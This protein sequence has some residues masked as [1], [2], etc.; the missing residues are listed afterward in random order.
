MSPI[1]QLELDHLPHAV[2]PGYII[3]EVHHP[4]R[5]RQLIAAI[6]GRTPEDVRPQV[7]TMLPADRARPPRHDARDR[8]RAVIVS[9]MSLCVFPF[10]ARPMIAA[11][12]GVDQPGFEQFIARRRQDPGVLSWSVAA[13]GRDGCAAVVGG[14]FR[15]AA[16]A[17]KGPA[18]VCLPL[19]M[20]V[21]PGRC[22]SGARRNHCSSRRC[23]RASA[24]PRSAGARVRAA[25]RAGGCLQNIESAAAGGQ[26]ARL[27][28]NAV[29]RPDPS[30][31][32]QPAVVP[33][34]EGPYDISVRVD[35]RIFDPALEPRLALAKADLAESQARLRVALFSLRDEVNEAFFT[36]AL[37]QE[38]IGAL[39][40]TLADLE[41]RLRETTIRVR[42][43]AAIPGEAAAIEATLLQQ[44]QQEEELR[45]NKKA[46]LV[47]LTSLTGRAIEADAALALPALDDA[48]AQARQELDRLHA[49]PEYEQFA[50]ARDR[51]ARQ[52][53]LTTAAERP[54][55]SAFDLNVFIKNAV[56]RGVIQ[57][58]WYLTNIFA[59]FEIWS[60][61]ATLKTNNFC[62][63]VN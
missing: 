26:H 27:I 60:G 40:A 37:L 47:R 21:M 44:R 9:L 14:P 13:M 24:R 29:R 23:V 61:G 46:A 33:A 53:E 49:R 32:R 3:S 10:A 48:V 22:R 45:A 62:A 31:G 11:M 56:S 6:T 52:Q 2:L 58:T 16:P 18:Y 7:I 4:E 50:R 43:G 25:E 28:E 63:V 1:V 41:S 42:E 15:P 39:G 35:Q 38:Q 19:M 8:A 55:L 5:A 54:Q 51:A 36:A 17:L 20:L 12:L 30:A 59:G 57:N 34:A